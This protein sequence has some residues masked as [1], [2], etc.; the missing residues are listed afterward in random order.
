[1]RTSPARWHCSQM[2]SRAAP[3]EFCRVDDRPRHGLL[4]VSFTWAVA[5]VAGNALF[6]ESRRPI[7][8]QCVRNRLRLSRMAEQTLQ[9]DRAREVRTSGFFIAGSNVPQAAVRVIGERRLKQVI[10]GLN[11]ITVCVN[12]GAYDKGD[13][14]LAGFISAF[15]SL[16]YAGGG[17]SNGESSFGEGV[18]ERSVGLR[19]RLAERMGHRRLP[20]AQHLFRMAVRTPP[21]SGESREGKPQ[22]HPGPHCF[23]HPHLHYIYHVAWMQ[24]LVGEARLAAHRTPGTFAVVATATREGSRPCVRDRAINSFL[25]STTSGM[26]ASA[27]FHIC[28]NI[29]Y[30]ARACSTLPFP[31]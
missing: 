7:P 3:C 18:L 8:V 25:A 15:K 1:M 16:N 30:A 23:C 31:S 5:T 20:V 9:R 26:S 2:L 24:Q 19:S 14:L 21:I 29:S 10:A 22:N 6:Q 11:Q 13:F 12:P 28:R 4:L 27:P 17:R